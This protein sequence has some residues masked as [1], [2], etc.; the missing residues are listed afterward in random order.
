MKSRRSMKIH[1]IHNI[2]GIYLF[3]KKRWVIFF[4]LNIWTPHIS[5]LQREINCLN[6]EHENHGFQETWTLTC[7]T[8]VKVTLLMKTW[9]D[10]TVITNILPQADSHKT[11]LKVGFCTTVLICTFPIRKWIWKVGKMNLAKKSRSPDS[12]AHIHLVARVCL[13]PFSTHKMTRL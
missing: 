4:I 10:P 7:K 5:V 12:V 3:R 13:L 8:R 2:Y 6:R 11:I 9:N 1:E